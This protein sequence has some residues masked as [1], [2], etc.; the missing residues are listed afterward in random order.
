MGFNLVYQS[1]IDIFPQI[2]K[3]LLRAVAIEHSKDVD[4]AVDSVISEIIPYWSQRSFAV[5]PPREDIRPVGTS[6]GGG[7]SEAENEEQSKLLRHRTVSAEREVD[8]SSSVPLMTG[9]AYDNDDTVGAHLTGSTNDEALTTSAIENEHEEQS[10][11]LS[12]TVGAEKE[13]GSS[14]VVTSMTRQPYDNDGSIG[15]HVPGSTNDSA[16]ANSTIFYNSCYG[17]SS[18]STGG[19]ELILLGSAQ[20]NSHQSGSVDKPNNLTNEGGVNELPTNWA[21]DKAVVSDNLMDLHCE[22]KDF[23]GPCANDF[24]MITCDKLDRAKSCS[25]GTLLEGKSS[26][27]EVVPSSPQEDTMVTICGG[28]HV[29]IEADASASTD[30]FEKLEAGSSID[31]KP[32]GEFP[33]LQ[34]DTEDNAKIIITRS[35]QIC[36]VDLLEEIIE[37]SKNHK[38]TLFAAMESVMNMMREVEVQEKAA[39]A[40]VEDAARG[41][42][43]I[44]VEVEKLKTML[45]HA[46]ETNNM[47]AGEVYGEK[48]I[49]A[50]ELK[51]LQAR[52]LSLSDERDKSLAILD[53]MHQSLEARLSVAEK[54]KKAAELEKLEKVESARNALAEQEAFMEMVVRDSKILQQEAEENS[55]LREFLIDRGHVVD[56]LQ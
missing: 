34:K 17:K 32:N 7:E 20:E 16:L 27:V 3:R 26:V 54:L 37:V 28:P 9:Q 39:E 55:K 45:E 11:L 25:D 22:W 33:V 46:K 50:T 2:D 5:F 38:K 18:T 52:L 14:S 21:Q 6:D 42:L 35:G 24:D 4:A 51:E 56:A 40:A 29:D 36:R 30:E 43:D 10:K 49:L 53:E 8:T 47:H 15:A 12:Q 44:L 31:S 13:V 1:L 23:E 48:A 41:G 19:E